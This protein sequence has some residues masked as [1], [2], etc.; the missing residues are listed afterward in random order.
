MMAPEY[1]TPKPL[2][3][4]SE[5]VAKLEND[6]PLTLSIREEE[7]PSPTLTHLPGLGQALLLR[8]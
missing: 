4:K 8:L 3:A 2:G 5:G 7:E 1:P 6:E